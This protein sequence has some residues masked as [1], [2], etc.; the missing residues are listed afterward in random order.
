[1]QFNK[2][3]PL[4]SWGGGKGWNE[5]ASFE[6]DSNRLKKKK[7]RRKAQL[8]SAV[9]FCAFSHTKLGYH[10]CSALCYYDRKKWISNEVSVPAASTLW[11]SMDHKHSQMYFLN[12]KRPWGRRSIV[13]THFLGEP[14]LCWQIKLLIEKLWKVCIGSQRENL[15]N[16]LEFVQFIPGTFGDLKLL[17]AVCQFWHNSVRREMVF[18]PGKGLVA[19]FTCA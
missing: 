5:A 2:I 7:Y 19:R 14:L 10:R 4:K 17:C 16:I 8:L 13:N 15:P 12:A 9:P 1:M 3:Q 11:I 18:L 6:D